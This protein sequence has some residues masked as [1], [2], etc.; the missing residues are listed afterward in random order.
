MYDTS[1]LKLQ[2]SLLMSP[3]LLFFEPYNALVKA[4]GILVILDVLTGGVVAKKEG[5][6]LTSRRFLSKFI[7]VTLFLVGLSAAG[8]ASPLLQVFGI[9]QYM[10]GKWICAFYGIYELFSIL[11]NLGKLGLPIAKQFGDLLKSK[12]PNQSKEEQK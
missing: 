2:Y 7:H 4:I 9:E 10:A 12:L 6:D 5:K 8:A 1:K 11:E 3:L